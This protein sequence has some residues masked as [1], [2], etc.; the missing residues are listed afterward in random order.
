MALNCG[1]GRA[2]VWGAISAILP[3]DVQLFAGTVV[4]NIARLGAADAGQVVVPGALAHAHDMILRLPQG[5]TRLGPGGAGLSG[6][7]RQRIGLARAVY[8]QPRLVVL[9][10]E[11]GCQSG[12]R[13][14]KGPAGDPECAA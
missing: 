5:Y 10:E 6:G 1:N 12:W 7:Q 14:R 4:E 3:Q 13:G 2:N 8:G 9:D 11:A